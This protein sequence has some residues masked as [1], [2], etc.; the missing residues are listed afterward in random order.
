[1]LP[2]GAPPGPPVPEDLPL[3][4]KA[5]AVLAISLE[6]GWEAHATEL[7]RRGLG[8]VVLLASA[9]ADPA[10]AAEVVA[11]MQTA[12]G[13][14]PVA[15]PL[16]V[17][18]DEEGGRVS[19]L[20]RGPASLPGAAALGA[21]ADL[22]L[23]EEAGRA[24][25]L[26]LAACGI[27]WDLAPVCDLAGAD[28]PGLNGRAFSREPEACARLAGAF[29]R[30]LAAGGAIAC[31]KHFP[32]HGGTTGDSHHALPVLAG[33][34][35]LIA[36]R[37]PFAAAVADGIPMV[38]IGH[39]LVPDLD[40][41]W[42][43]SLSPAAYGVL[44][45]EL[46]FD[47]VVVTDSLGMR[48]CLEAAGGIGAAAIQALAA[49]ADLILVGP[50]PDAHLQAHA[51]IMAAVGAGVLPAGRLDDAVRRLLALKQRHGL[52][53]RALP[54]GA[55]APHLLARPADSAL[56]RRI[57][58]AAVA[59]LRPGPACPQP[60]V[61]VSGA[62]TPKALVAAAQAWW[63]QA[64]LRSDGSGPWLSLGEATHLL[65][66]PPVPPGVPAGRLLAAWD[67]MPASLEAL[68]TSAT[69]PTSPTG[70]PAALLPWGE[71]HLLWSFG[72]EA[73]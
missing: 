70:R 41:R 46:G 28:N 17:G 50:G 16:L 38:M 4:A 21:A 71:S 56:A 61:L 65:I 47:G 12:A 26:R 5:L 49:G 53:R 43:A 31:A 68:L 63:P 8:A 20:P 60:E 37:R 40:Q 14:S 59:E 3:D 13:Q 69:D 22:A 73:I 72:R 2:A 66:A 18:A 35:E 32:G 11:D 36:A 34:P 58:R 44:R 23:C 19:R 39:L 54:D 42:P 52:A 15:A 6:A 30:G 27:H 25:A 45:Q 33:G 67:A 55:A 7:T 10:R 48:G 62:T 51:A 57:A 1:M 24:T 9:L 29:A 64:A